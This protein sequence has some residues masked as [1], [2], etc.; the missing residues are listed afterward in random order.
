M[1]LRTGSGRALYATHIPRVSNTMAW[2]IYWKGSVSDEFSLMTAAITRSL[3]DSIPNPKAIPNAK[4]RIGS[5]RA[6]MLKQ[7]KASRQSSRMLTER[8]RPKAM[9][10]MIRTP[11]CEYEMVEKVTR[12][13]ASTA[14]RKITTPNFIRPEKAE[15]AERKTSIDTKNS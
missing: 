6:F 3:A 2:K 1:G 5:R 12:A 13:D 14:Q 9:S 10:G 4:S 15:S 11:R 8:I 7:R